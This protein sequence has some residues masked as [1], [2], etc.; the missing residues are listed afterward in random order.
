MNKCRHVL[1]EDC[2]IWSGDDAITPKQDNTYNNIFP[3]RNVNDHTY[4]NIVVFTRKCAV[5]VGS[6]TYNKDFEFFDMEFRNFDVVYADRAICIWSDYGALVHFM[7][8]KDFNIEKI[9]NVD[10]KQSHI[11]CRIDEVGNTIKNIDFINIKALEPAPR[12]S[13]FNGD[14]LNST[15]NGKLVQY[16]NIKFTDYT[17][18][19]V[20]V[21]SL[22]DVNAKFNL[23][24]DLAS[25]DPGAFSFY[26]SPAEGIAENESK[27]QFTAYPNPM[28]ERCKIDLSLEKRES[29]KITVRNIGG[30]VIDEVLDEQLPVR[31]DLF[32][33]K[34]L[35]LQAFLF[36]IIKTGKTLPV[37]EKGHYDPGKKQGPVQAE[38]HRGI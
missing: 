2:L 22:D 1:V 10:A 3:L 17:I 24:D 37:S 11:H 31:I 23:Q 35:V 28:Q 16:Y 38:N 33:L 12:G 18:A 6:E 26:A 34:Y 5:K 4:N 20:P 13:T 8:F 30:Q 7:T 9:G 14:N 36:K 15:I 27:I 29:V 19:G 32:F 21:L 25:A